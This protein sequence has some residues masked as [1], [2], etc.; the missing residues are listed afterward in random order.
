MN[1]ENEEYE[2]IVNE[3]NNKLF[4]K[5]SLVISLLNLKL[6]SSLFSSFT[7]HFRGS[8][9][10]GESHMILYVTL[11]LCLLGFCTTILSFL[12]REPSS[13][14]KWIGGTLNLLQTL[15]LIGSSLL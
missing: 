15:L 11:F 8:K 2:D 14:Y 4:S 13:W 6:F 1:I 3:G 10:F 12:K 5:L 9:S 7:K